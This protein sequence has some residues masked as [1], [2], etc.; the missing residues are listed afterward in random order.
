MS[1]TARIVKRKHLAKFELVSMGDASRKKLVLLGDSKNSEEVMLEV[2]EE[3]S[4][5]LTDMEELERVTKMIT[6]ENNEIT[7][8]AAALK[9]PGEEFPIILK[10]IVQ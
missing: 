1:N 8:A 4:V 10:Y 5:D 9:E 7:D 6:L 2:G 3:N